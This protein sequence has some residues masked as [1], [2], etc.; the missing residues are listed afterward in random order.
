MLQQFF[1]EKNLS[2]C[3][4]SIINCDAML[5][6][7]QFNSKFDP[8]AQPCKRRKLTAMRHLI[9]YI[10]VVKCIIIMIV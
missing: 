7:I 9:N 8:Q 6:S 5:S 1:L 2:L 4:Q 10:R 3:T